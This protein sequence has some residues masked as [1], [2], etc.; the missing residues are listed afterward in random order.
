MCSPSSG[1]V[2]R[3]QMIFS[4]AITLRHSSVNVGH[5]GHTTSETDRGISRWLDILLHSP[6][7]LI[8]YVH[9]RPYSLLCVG[10]NI[11]SIDF[12]VPPSSYRTLST[13]ELGE[14]DEQL[15]SFPAEIPVVSA[16]RRTCRSTWLEVYNE[17]SRS[18]NT[19]RG[20]ANSCYPEAFS[21]YVFLWHLCLISP[22]ST[23]PFIYPS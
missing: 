16:A 18:C 11:A 1:V 21:L 13:F 19:S 23:T 17:N 4:T 5:H 14:V 15:D 6:H 3:D 22:I 2:C 12:V 9:G 20:S 8:R 10:Q 7:C